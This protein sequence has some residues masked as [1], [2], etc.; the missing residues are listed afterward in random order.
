MKTLSELYEI[1][2]LSVNYDAF[3]NVLA[4]MHKLPT[5]DAN[6]SKLIEKHYND[7]LK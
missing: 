7:K 4:N 3:M 2:K 1:A 5:T 6:S